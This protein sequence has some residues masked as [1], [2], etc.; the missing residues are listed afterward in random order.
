MKLTGFQFKQLFWLA[1]LFIGYD[2]MP[3]TAE[4]ERFVTRTFALSQETEIEVVSK[5]GDIN[6]ELWDNDSVRFD[7]RLVVRST[8]QSK[9]DKT[10]DFID[11]D[12]KANSYYV[13]AQTV[14]EQGGSF[15]AEVNDITSNLFSTGTTTSIDYT[16]YIPQ[17]AHLSIQNK[18]GNVYLTDFFGKLSIDLS[19]GNFKA[20]D[21]MGEINLSA[22]FGDVDIS[23]VSRGSISHNYG[24]LTIGSAGNLSL[25]NRLSNVTIEQISELTLDAKRSKYN[26]NKAGSISGEAYF[27]NITVEH[28]TNQAALNMRYGDIQFMKIDQNAKSINIGSYNSD[29]TLSMSLA[30]HYKIKMDVTEKTEVMYSSLITQIKTEEPQSSDKKIHVDCQVGDNSKPAVPITLSCEAGRVSLKIN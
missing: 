14:F 22:N 5:Y 8:K 2:A 19:N 21:L 7:I 27:S 25:I 28:L 16:V 3:Q 30:N 23:S 20:H 12:F 17:K 15:W 11:F 4:K 18:Y 26:F 24:D 13:I 9:V 10:F 29:L 6:V 1:L